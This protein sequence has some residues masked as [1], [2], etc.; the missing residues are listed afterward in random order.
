MLFSKKD[1]LDIF[2]FK[3]KISNKKKALE[4]VSVY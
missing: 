2:E 4:N 3:R 1:R